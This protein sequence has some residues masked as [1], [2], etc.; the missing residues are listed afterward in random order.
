[1]S[2]SI[3]LHINQ[4][5][6]Q[7]KFEHKFFEATDW[8]IE[9]EASLINKIHEVFE[10]L[11]PLSSSCML[12]FSIE[13]KNYEE[14]I[15]RLKRIKNNRTNIKGAKL[16]LREIEIL[17]LL[18]QGLTNIEIADKLFISYE[19]VKSH[20]KHILEKTGAKNTAALINYYHQTFFDK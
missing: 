8:T 15:F 7:E 6:K 1:M 10:L 14:A 19:T 13:V 18:M 3:F 9:S 20:R 2:A 12:D 5:E 11:R 4:I 16:T 17:G